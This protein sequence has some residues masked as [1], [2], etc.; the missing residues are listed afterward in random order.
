MKKMFQ[1]LLIIATWF[2]AKAR[3][4]EEFI[5]AP[6]KL[7]SSMPF[8]MLQGGI[9][10]VH[11]CLAGHQDSLNF[12]FDT[13]CGGISLDSSACDRLHLSPILS[14]KTIRGIAGIRQVRFVYG[15]QLQFPRFTAD[16]LDFHVN[17]YDM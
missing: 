3:S 2:P 14:D 10:V 15:Q 6:A 17:D 7:L 1:I 12:I 5:Q 4:Q 9:I 16:S 13:G 11:A 8:S